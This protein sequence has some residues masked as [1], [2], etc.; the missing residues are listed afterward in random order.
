MRETKAQLISAFVF[1]TK[2]STIHLLPKSRNVKSLAI[3][4]GCAARFVLDLVGNIED[5]FSNDAALMTK[6]YKW[7]EC[8]SHPVIHET[9]QAAPAMTI[10]MICFIFPPLAWLYEE[11]N[12]LVLYTLHGKN[13]KEFN[14]S[15][16]QVLP[17]LLGYM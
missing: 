10:P 16:G 7:N 6:K 14:S 13:T 4:C 12:S 17:P 15:Y 5:R 3:F 2:I 1:A 8:N 9:S 11:L